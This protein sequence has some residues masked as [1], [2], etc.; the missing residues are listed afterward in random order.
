MFLK[1]LD[2]TIPPQN[3]WNIELKKEEINYEVIF[4][5]YFA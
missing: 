5:F 4:F 1:N 3:D 2:F